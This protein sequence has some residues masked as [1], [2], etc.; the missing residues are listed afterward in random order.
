MAGTGT[1]ES[2]TINHQPWAQDMDVPFVIARVRLSDAPDVILTT[3]IVDCPVD[4]IRIGDPVAVSFEEQEGIYF[5]L[6][7][8]SGAAA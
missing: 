1:V 8:R 2:F 7:A 4:A 6:F 3:N 5:P